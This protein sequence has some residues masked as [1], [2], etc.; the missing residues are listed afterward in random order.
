MRP[1][2]AVRQEINKALERDYATIN[3]ES[4]I[5]TIGLAPDTESK[6]GNESIVYQLTIPFSAWQPVYQLRLKNNQCEI[7]ASAKVDNPTDEDLNDYI[8]SV[9]TGDPNTFETDLADVRKPRRQ[10]VNIISDQ[11]SYDRKSSSWATLSLRLSIGCG[12]LCS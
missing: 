5:V 12:K 2:R 7:E 1:A 9:A 10:R 4:T 11:A 6:E 3:P 8:V